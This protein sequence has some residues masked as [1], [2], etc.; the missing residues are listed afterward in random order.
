MTG[1]LSRRMLLVVPVVPVVLTAFG[2][3][4]WLRGWP[5]GVDSSVYRGGAVLFVHGHS[6]Y[7][8]SDL[9]YLGQSFTYPPAG[10][11]V[12]APFAF[13]PVQ[14][15]WVVMA[16]ASL[17][18]LAVVIRVAIAHV[19]FW[20][21]P[22]GRSTLVLTAATLGLLP[23]Y[24]T[25]GLG[26]VNL[27]LMAMVTADVLVVSARGS[28]WG[29]LLTG[30]AAAVF[31]VPLIFVVHLFVTG[32]RAA[33]GRALAAF[34]G[35]QGLTLAVAPQDC[36]YWTRYVFQIG[37]IGDAQ[38]PDNQSLDGLIERLTSAS[39][40]PVYAGWGIGALLA[41]PALLLMLR[42]SRRGQGLLALCVTAWYALLLTPISWR[43]TWVWIAPVM[44]ALLS[45]LQLPWSRAR[46]DGRGWW[47]LAA[48]IS[49]VAALIAV[50]STTPVGRT[51]Q[52]RPRSVSPVWF[53]VLSNTYVLSAIAIALVLVACS[54]RRPARWHVSE[55]DRD[56]AIVLTAARPPVSATRSAA[57]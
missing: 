12:F 4:A 29:G 14:L 9:G 2:I 1:L 42:F 36:A 21:Y 40:W 41:V 34:A 43:P 46:R 57:P 38:I 32:R 54:L 39:G 50:F 8:A 22:A 27:I 48:G 47:Q 24:H 56:R 10:A 49:A 5:L 55:L 17:L 18:S 28:R 23:V 26:Q 30:A 25:V 52:H 6:P 44:V 35:L 37:R 16:S 45:W 33:A 31:L 13:L 7:Q 3:V 11:L 15:A 19:P 53:F 20:R 51:L